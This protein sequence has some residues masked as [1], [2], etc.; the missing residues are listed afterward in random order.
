MLNKNIK[1]FIIY[2]IFL[3]FNLINLFKKAQISL[4][5][6]K[7]ITIL[8]KYLDFFNI[9]LEEKTL[10]LL[11]LTKLN[12][13]AIK[14]IKNKLLLYSVI[15][16]LKLIEL[17]SFKIHIKINL[18]NSFIQ[19]LKLLKDT[20]IFFIKKPDSNFQLYLTIRA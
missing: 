8:S 9:F 4:L 7:K 19:P 15:Y 3:S 13:H 5:L 14:L 20:F 16:S 10:K 18:A 2:V 17:K 6:I 1:T 11:K 12:H